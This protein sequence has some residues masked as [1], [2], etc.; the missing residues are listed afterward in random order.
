MRRIGSCLAAASLILL[1]APP[2]FHRVQFRNRD[3]EMMMRAANVE[4]MVALVLVS[5]S[6]AGTLLLITDMMF[7]VELA[8]VAAN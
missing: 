7:P 2:A 8:V 6:L 3:K 5:L 1:L 4:V